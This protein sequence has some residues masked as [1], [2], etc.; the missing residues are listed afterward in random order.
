MALATEPG[1]PHFPNE[2]YMAVASPASGLDGT[3]VVLDGVTPPTEEYGCPHGVPWYVAR[4][5]GALVELSGSRGDMTLTQCLSE[6][7]SRTVTA[8]SK[9]CDLSHPRTPQA[10]VVAARWGKGPEASVEYLVLSDSVLLIETAKGVA[11]GPS[12]DGPVATEVR[13]ILDGRLDELR[14]TVRGMPRARRV[15]TIES[16]RNAEGGFH[17]AAADPKVAEHAVTGTVPRDQV[18]SLTA[19]TDG[20][21]RWVEVFHLGDW[22]ALHKLL[23]ERGPEALLAEVRTAERADPSGA[24]YP[25]GKAHDDAT[26]VFV[27]L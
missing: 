23:S 21:S 22:K 1:D 24:R 12:A 6:A 5:G 25:R 14:P 17:T 20:A 11:S 18:R 8:H 7:I 26:A 27:P 9:T 3:L 4:L 13:P 10:T 2:D 15:A 19:L 16:L